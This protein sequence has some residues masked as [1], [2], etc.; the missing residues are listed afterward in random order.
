[1]NTYNNT[2]L[3]ELI[4]IVGPD[5]IFTEKTQRIC[6]RF[7]NVLEHRLNPPSF[8]PDFVVKIKSVEE[9]SSILKCANKYKVPVVAWGGGTDFVGANSPIKGGIVLD[10]KGLNKI[11]INKEENFVEAGA[12]TTLLR[13][14]EEAE[15]SGFLFPHEIISQPGATLGG[16]IATNSVGYRS[17]KYRYVR[18]LILGIEAVLPTGEI[19]RTKP[20]FKT[21]TGYD[22]VS[23]LVGSEG[24]LGIITKAT[25]RLDPKPERREMLFYLFNSFEDGFSAAKEIHSKITP[26]MFNITELS[27]LKYSCNTIKF[28][29]K[30]MDSKLMSRYLH[31]RYIKKNNL[32]KILEKILSSNPLT[33]K[34]VRYL[35]N[36]IKGNNCITVLMIGI[37]GESRVVKSKK[38]VVNTVAK[39]FGGLKFDNKSFYEKRF[40]FYHEEGRDIIQNYTTQIQDPIMATFDFSLPISNIK[41]MKGA[42]H[43]II[44]RYNK[45]KMIDI[46]LHSSLSSMGVDLIISTLSKREYSHFFKELRHEVLKLNGSLSFAHGIGTKL[47]PYLEGDIGLEYINTM[48]KIKKALDPNNI[49]NPGKIGDASWNYLKSP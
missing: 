10:M 19:I 39:S 44:K 42:I 25:L 31:L 16:S 32:G 28:L 36:T 14:T 48:H 29:D 35:D 37:E 8:L 11:Q 17:G 1:M 5:K 41:E 27:F 20:L 9:I 24:T 22:L 33:G 21:S 47:L 34:A 49:L 6:Y 26:D 2:V 4:K 3:K 38:H 23:L 45:I 7:G 30:Y 18:N 46:V 13:I 12:G 15:K 43:E 40:V